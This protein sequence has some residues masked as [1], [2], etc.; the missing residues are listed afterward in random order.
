M[1]LMG[2]LLEFQI[3]EFNGYLIKKISNEMITNFNMF[4]MGTKN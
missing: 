4:S 3:C 2:S 1:I